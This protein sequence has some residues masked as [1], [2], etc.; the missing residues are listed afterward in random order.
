V[1]A[2]ILRLTT[3]TSAPYAAKVSAMD[4]PMPRLAPVTR[5]IL[6]FKL[7]DIILSSLLNKRIVGFFR[8]D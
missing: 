8:M 2:W 3:T 4:R 1:R 6:S 7:N 5:A